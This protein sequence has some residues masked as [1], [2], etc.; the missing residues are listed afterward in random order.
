MIINIYYYQHLLCGQG[1]NVFQLNSWGGLVPNA[2][3]ISS[4]ISLVSLGTTFKQWMFSWNYLTLE[5]PR[6]VVLQ[7]L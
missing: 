6:I 3:S 2:V 5:H 4:L 1:V 7:S